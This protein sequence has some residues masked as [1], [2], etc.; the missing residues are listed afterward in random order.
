MPLR[1]S[2]YQEGSAVLHLIPRED[3]GRKLQCLDG[4]GGDAWAYHAYILA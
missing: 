2:V 1:S 3:P 4:N